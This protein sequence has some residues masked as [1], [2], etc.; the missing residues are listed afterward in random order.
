MSIRFQPKKKVK[1]SWTLVDKRKSL[2]EIRDAVEAVFPL[3]CFVHSNV[4]SCTYTA[5]TSF[6]SLSCGMIIL[7]FGGKSYRH[8]VLFSHKRGWLNLGTP[9]SAIAENI[10]YSWLAV[11]FGD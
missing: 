6:H 7:Y 10:V 1:R 11:Q 2:L 9:S 5:S 4:I 8:E 3:C